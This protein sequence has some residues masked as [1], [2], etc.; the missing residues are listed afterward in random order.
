MNPIVAIIKNL[1]MILYLTIADNLNS[2]LGKEQ[3]KQKGKKEEDKTILKWYTVNH[4]VM[5]QTRRN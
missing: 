4:L 3:E 1:Q 5:T 2:Y